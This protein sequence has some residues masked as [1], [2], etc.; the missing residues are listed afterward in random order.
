MRWH[1]RYRAQNA[2]GTGLG[3]DPGDREASLI[4]SVVSMKGA[5]QLALVL[6]LMALGVLGNHFNLPLF[7]GVNIIFGSV[8]VWLALAWVGAP[9]AILVAIAAGAYTNVLWDH[10]YAFLIFVAEAGFVA[11]LGQLARH[12]GQDSPPL[13]WRVCLYWLLIGVPLV[14]VF[15]RFNLDMPP[16]QVVLIALKQ[17]LNG[18]FNA[19]LAQL[20]LLSITLLWRQRLSLL[21]GQLLFS[22]L[23]T[24]M[25]MPAFTLLAWQN[26]DLRTGIE[27]EMRN[28]L[29]WFAD[30]A[31]L[32][33]E[34]SAADGITTTLTELEQSLAARL[35]T[36]AEPRLALQPAQTVPAK[37]SHVEGLSILMPGQEPPALMEQ[38]REARYQVSLPVALGSATEQLTI[39]VSTTLIIDQLHEQIVRLLA[40]LLAL[41]MISALA[42][43]QLSNLLT[44]PLQR[45][46]DTAVQ[47]PERI[48]AGQT[49]APLKP[50]PVREIQQLTGAI[51]RMGERLA[52]SF[53]NLQQERDTVARQRTIRGIQAQTL[54][55]LANE[56]ASEAEVTRQLCELSEQA[57]NGAHCA[58]V[59]PN[60]V[61]M[62]EVT[63]APTLDTDAVHWI[64]Q[65]LRT[66][67][68]GCCLTRAYTEGTPQYI[69][70]LGSELDLAPP[71]GLASAVEPPALW[72]RPIAGRD[73]QSL[74]VFL[75]LSDRP[76]G[77]GQ[78]ARELLET[79]ANLAALAFE[80][81]RLEQHHRVLVDALSQANTG[82]VIARR[83]NQDDYSISYVNRGFE[84]LTGYRTDEVLGRNCLFFHEK[85]D[86]DPEYA[87]V[88]A[89]LQSGSRCRSTL[90]NQRKDGTTFWSALSLTP[91][92]NA[93][94]EVSHFVAVQQDVS[95]LQHALEQVSHSE[96]LLKE[97]Q[98]ITHLGSWCLDY[99]S[100]RLIW[101]DETYRLFGYRPQSIPASLDAFFAAVHPEDQEAVRAELKAAPLRPDGAYCVECRLR[102]IDGVERR[103]LNQGRVNFDAEGQPQNLTGTSLD[104]TEQRQVE[105]E[106]RAQRERY[107]LVVDNLEDL[108]VRTDPEGR[109][110]FVSPSYCKLFDRHEAELAGQ[111][112]FSNRLPADPQAK[113]K[114]LNALQQP[115]H[116]HF[117]EHYVST[118]K[119]WR[120]LQ[121]VDRAIVDDSGQITGIVS[122]GRDITERKLAELDLLQREAIERELLDIATAFVL[123]TDQDVSGLIDQTL[124]RI[125]D[126]TQSDRTYLFQIEPDDSRMHNT[127]E[128]VA[129]GVTP[130]IEHLQDLPVEPFSATMRHMT[131][132]KPVIV[133]RVADL[134][135]DWAE[136]REILEFQGIQSV[137][138]VPLMEGAHSGERLIGFIGFDAVYAPREWLAAEVRFL[139]V[140][141]NLM[142]GALARERIYRDLVQSQ[143]RYDQVARL[144]R[145]VAWEVDANGLYTYISPVIADLLGL[146]PEAL[147]GKRHFYDLFPES[148]R[149]RLKGET[150]QYFEQKHTCEDFLNPICHADGSLVWVKTYGFPILNDDGSLRGFRGIDIDITDHYQAEQQLRASEA[151]LSAIFNQ[152]P[153]G[154]GI[155]DRSGR[156]TLVNHTLATL[157]GREPDALLGMSI[158]EVTHPEDLPQ[159]H[160]LHQQLLAGERTGFRITK[161]CIKPNGDLMWGDLRVLMIPQGD[162]EAPL[163]L[164][165]LEDITEVVQANERRQQLEQELA[166]YRHHLERLVN[167]SGQS[168]QLDTEAE[169]LLELGCEGLQMDLGEF[170]LLQGEMHYR[171]RTAKATAE[172]LEQPPSMAQALVALDQQEL[173]VPK[174]ISAE[175]LSASSRK[176]GWRSG[177]LLALPWNGPNGEA[178]TLVLNFWSREARPVFSDLHRELMRLIGQRLIALVY[179]EQ[180]QRLMVASKERETI[181]HLASGIAHDFN[182]LLGVIDGNLQ[183]LQTSLDQLPAH[184]AIKQYGEIID[185]T[186]SALGQAIVITSGMLSLSRA[187]GIT[188]TETPLEPALKELEHILFRVLPARIKLELKIAPA[189]HAETNTAFLQS[190]LLNL[191]LNARDAMP[192]GGHLSIQAKPRHWDGSE[193]LALGRLS[194]GEYVELRVADTGCGM[195]TETRQRLF[196]PLF[197]TKAEQRGHGLGMF[198]VQEFVLRSGAGLQVESQPGL[199]SVFRLLLPTGQPSTAHAAPATSALE[200][201]DGKPHRILVVDDDPRVRETVSRLLHTL[202]IDSE[203]AEDALDCLE[204]LNLDP[205][206][207]LVLTDLAMPQ[208]DGVE[209]CEL[210]NDLYPEI[211]VILMSGQNPANFGL[212]RLQHQPSVLPK[213][214]SLERLR[215]AL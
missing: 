4:Q 190:A 30:L 116:T 22:L 7:F 132:G 212:E 136:E 138:L 204:R 82:I 24:A 96:S 34:H 140:V 66:G 205:E 26:T 87:K 165:M 86:D 199:G 154:I 41:S 67:D 196:E 73:Q 159:E 193:Q 215:Q 175:Q 155:T 102:A 123:Q 171:L 64:N 77:L 202:D 79:G 187:G 101:S 161:R 203:M 145:S 170:G 111:D 19:A 130:M 62:L 47:L 90:R 194:P 147:I 201:K 152:A 169:A 15:Y 178:E 12:R 188:I 176:A 149:E 57:L 13:L 148:E 172:G 56:Q 39:E 112:A 146:Q 16:T 200:A 153:L 28:R 118:R 134:D 8:A 141:A 68:R 151:R 5:R 158:D 213:P 179:I 192:D 98:A 100:G 46:L 60:A 42:A 48:T 117:A 137:L 49:V 144:S 139:Q 186:L 211:R 207:D 65:S 74:G 163:P 184:P 6:T 99:T 78:L 71:P 177:L 40:T 125:G 35:P 143:A 76:Q 2:V 131:S 174:P 173:G 3:N 44:R 185:E 51:T 198:M 72:C 126:F 181:G 43:Q 162:G 191:A 37:P 208:M 209:L 70:D 210:L 10:P 183:F 142:V 92:H 69:S 156:F 36:A 18:I 32:R 157:L 127:H 103:M 84:E 11:G 95:A 121:W 81:Q 88:Q 85:D 54:L 63:V 91:L 197:S 119:G 9:A 180:V 114:A 124:Q 150:L 33:L 55:S 97:A 80:T 14:L 75:I 17:S 160:R 53:I 206:F 106:L 50:T 105:A 128:W 214:I 94:G 168:L 31:R 122:L 23:L 166:D 164:G 129:P 109:L 58:V 182:N 107:R 61:G 110:E 104:V 1:M 20:I 29:L 195:N 93:K 167:L 108:I 115:P 25:L 52:E 113:T 27:T 38:W 120:W 83:R 21:L 59:A 135:D 189:I 45:L 133:P 89:A